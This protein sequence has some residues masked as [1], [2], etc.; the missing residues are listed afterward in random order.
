MTSE[1]KR[2]AITVADEHVINVWTDE[3][4]GERNEVHVHPTFY[5]DNGTPICGDASDTPGDDMTY[6]RTEIT[7]PRIVACVNACAG[8]K[9]PARVVVDARKAM[10]AARSALETPGDLTQEEIG[11]VIDDLSV[12]IE[13]MGGES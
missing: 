10:E 2:G 8:L 13:I 12:I 7:D 4:D 5:Q 3:V 9:D 1:P 6:D 11:H